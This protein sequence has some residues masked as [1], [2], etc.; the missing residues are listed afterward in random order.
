LEQYGAAI[1]DATTSIALDPKYAKG[2]YRRGSA[3]LA[4]GKYKLGRKDFQKVC[5]RHLLLFQLFSSLI[6]V[7]IIQIFTPF[8]P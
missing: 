5:T 3:H 7:F 8:T 6:S 1:T 2:Y 4:L